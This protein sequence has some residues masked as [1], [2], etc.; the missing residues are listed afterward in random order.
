MKIEP[1]TVVRLTYTLEI[2]GRPTPERLRGPFSIEFVFG[3]DPLLPMLEKA[4]YGRKK[5]ELIEVEIPPEKAFG[6]YDPSLVSEIP[7][8][9]FRRPEE[10]EEGGWYQEPIEGG[11]ALSFTVKEIKDDS[12]VVDFN[13]PAAGRA[14]RLKAEVEDVRAATVQEILRAAG[15]GRGGG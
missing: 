3:R 11:K 4:L 2:Q 15:I 14:V 8:A 1:D 5:D 9:D 7:K 12:V 10:L 6:R 13:H